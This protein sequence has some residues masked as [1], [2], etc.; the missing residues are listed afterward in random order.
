MRIALALAVIALTSSTGCAT[1]L[2]GQRNRLHIFSNSGIRSVSENGRSLPFFRSPDG[3]T[4]FEVELDQGQPHELVV[5]TGGAAHTV[6]TSTSIGAG[7]VV[8]DVFVHMIICPIVDA[9]TGAWFSFDPVRLVDPPESQRR[10]LP[11][12]PPSRGAIELEPI[13]VAPWRAP[14]S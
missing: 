4:S 10:E 13:P 9:A 12:P 1:L 8:L 6:R 14:A 11:V 5:H 2:N 3:D 7:W